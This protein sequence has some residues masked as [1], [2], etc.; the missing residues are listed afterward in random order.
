MGLKTYNL[1]GVVA[2][3]TNFK[4]SD[5][6][7]LDLEVKGKADFIE[8][9]ITKKFPPATGSYWISR[10]E[11]RGGDASGYDDEVGYYYDYEDL[12]ATDRDMG[13]YGQTEEEICDMYCTG[14]KG[15]TECSGVK[16]GSC[17]YRSFEDP[18]EG[19]YAHFL[20]TASGEDCSQ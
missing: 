20:L 16:M 11:M 1:T 19:S 18:V 4:C 15:T 7:S 13:F 5:Y 8:Q 2:P 14:V 10:F 6:W 12:G 3:T 9:F 17:W